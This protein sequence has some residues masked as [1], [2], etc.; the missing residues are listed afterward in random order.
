MKNYCIHCDEECDFAKEITI[1]EK[2]ESVW[3]ACSKCKSRY[4]NLPKSPPEVRNFD[5]LCAECGVV[6][7]QWEEECLGANNGWGHWYKCTK[8]GV[9][10]NLPDTV[11]DRKAH[12]EWQAAGCPLPWW[13]RPLQCVVLLT[14]ITLSYLFPAVMLSLYLASC[15]SLS[16]YCM[17]SGENV[18]G[19]LLGAICFFIL[20]PIIM[21]IYILF[22]A[23]RLPVL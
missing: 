18:H 22:L 3:F 14:I 23:I 4:S 13:F 12:M 8:C 9:S 16:I 1:Y 10:S 20:A 21:P 7:F 17:W 6:P 5:Y 15:Y 2:I 19:S 11:E